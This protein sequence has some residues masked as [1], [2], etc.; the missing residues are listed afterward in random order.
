MGIFKHEKIDSKYYE[1][2]AKEELRR[3][4][5]SCLSISAASM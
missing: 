1:K 5:L 4:N 3:G 2:L